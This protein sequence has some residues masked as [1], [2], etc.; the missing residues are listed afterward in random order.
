M[1][2]YANMEDRAVE[3]QRN[4]RSRPHIGVGASEMVSLL[5][6]LLLHLCSS[7]P[8]LTYKLLA[9]P[10]QRDEANDREERL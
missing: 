1:S 9:V 3:D 8:G 2:R 10:R 4:D 6:L 7:W 5:G